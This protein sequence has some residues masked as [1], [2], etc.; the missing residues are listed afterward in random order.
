MNESV[1]ALRAEALERIQ[2]CASETDLEQLRVEV[3]GRKGRL[4]SLLRGLK[5]LPAEER[6]KAGELLNETRQQIEAHLEERLAVLKTEAKER[7][8]KE[9]R[10]DITLPGTR[11]ERGHI[12]PLTLVM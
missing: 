7:A 11:W 6:P 12:H 4:T 1:D 8:L 2:N 10:I 5:D 3:L 9:E